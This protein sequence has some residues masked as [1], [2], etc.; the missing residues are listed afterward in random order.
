VWR[1]LLTFNKEEIISL[2]RRIG[3]FDLSISPYKDCCSLVARHPAVR[4]PLPRIREAESRLPLDSMVQEALQQLD[5]W[6]IGTRD[7][8]PAK[9][10]TVHSI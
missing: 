5:R 4:P 3:T 2:A 8:P 7:L 10:E 6:E 9:D 1:P